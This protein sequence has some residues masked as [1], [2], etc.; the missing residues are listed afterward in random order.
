M[1]ISLALLLAPLIVLWGGLLAFALI[2]LL[3]PQRRVAGGN[4]LV[5]ALV[6]VLIG[7]IG[8][9]VYLLAGRREAE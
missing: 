4:K 2:D 3:R 5:W 9:L 8:P 6:I 7:T 1:R